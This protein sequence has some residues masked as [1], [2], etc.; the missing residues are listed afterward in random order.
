MFLSSIDAKQR[1]AKQR[2]SEIRAVLEK[3]SVPS[4]SVGGVTY[5]LRAT[6][7]L[8]HRLIE[9]QS[10]HS[11]GSVKEAIFK[12]LMLGLLTLERLPP[13]ANVIPSRIS[14]PDDWC[15]QRGLRALSEDELGRLRDE[16]WNA[17]RVKPEED[18]YEQQG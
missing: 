11:F 13:Q 4:P 6:Y 9:V 17:P 10:R 2:F 14:S 16:G 5:G 12:A 8:R 3:T 15:K 18:I 7:G 1:V